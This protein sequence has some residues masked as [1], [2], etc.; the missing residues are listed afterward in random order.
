M[1]TLETPRD[2][3]LKTL[4]VAT[5]GGRTALQLVRAPMP[6]LLKSILV[7]EGEKIDKGASLC[8]LEAMKMENE[9]KAPG[10]FIVGTISV[11][12]GNPVEKGATLLQ[13]LPIE[14]PVS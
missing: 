14:E 2:R 10:D 1:I 13:L 5:A 8:I 11:E 4:S 6:G 3:H 7:N 9:I 12:P